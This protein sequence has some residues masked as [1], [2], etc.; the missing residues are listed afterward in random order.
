MSL[1]HPSVPI[2]PH[3]PP[4]FVDAAGHCPCAGDEVARMVIAASSGKNANDFLNIGSFRKTHD[5]L[6]DMA[7]KGDQAR[8]VRIAFR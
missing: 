8:R 5:M 6:V 1:Q 4:I 7:W 2:V 3:V